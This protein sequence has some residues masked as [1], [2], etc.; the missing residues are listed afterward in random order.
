MTVSVR[1]ALPTPRSSKGSSRLPAALAWVF[2]TLAAVAIYTNV[3]SDDAPL[4]ARTE[5]LARAHVGCADRCRITRTSSQRNVFDH[6]AE[7]DI[8]GAGTVHVRCRRTAIVLGEHVCR[9]GSVS[10]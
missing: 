1:P 9:A 10:R 8:E 2:C 6:R 5:Q 4:R 7:Y 3:A